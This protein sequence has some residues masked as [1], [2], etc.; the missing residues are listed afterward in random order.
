MMF[1]ILSP[2]IFPV[3]VINLGTNKNLVLGRNKNPTFRYMFSVVY[4]GY[5]KLMTHTIK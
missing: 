5:N 1:S 4:G 3:T 2:L